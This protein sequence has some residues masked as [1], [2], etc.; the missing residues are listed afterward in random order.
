MCCLIPDVE[1]I[2]DFDGCKIIVICK[3]TGEILEDLNQWVV[4]KNIVDT[5]NHGY[6]CRLARICQLTGEIEYLS[7]EIENCN[8]FEPNA[9]YCVPPAALLYREDN[10][11]SDLLFR[12][13]HI[14]EATPFIQ[15]QT[16]FGITGLF[17][18]PFTAELTIAYES[19]RDLTPLI[20]I[21][22]VQ[23]VVLR[24]ST[25][26]FQRGEGSVVLNDLADLPPGAYFI[27]I[28]DPDSGYFFT[29]MMVRQ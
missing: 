26:F 18:N 6:L 7:E 27:T 5:D 4:C 10:N 24:S 1:V 8:G 20:S 12:T 23:G 13:D 17:P 21:K 22:S 14:N 19:E 25:T 11:R 16:T 3:A 29:R 28:S 9:P 15:N 2:T